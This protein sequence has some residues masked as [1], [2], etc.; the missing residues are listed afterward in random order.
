MQNIMSTKLF[1]LLSTASEATNIELQTAYGCF[2]EHMRNVSQFE[3]DPSET[4]RTLS[5]T[6]VELAFL[7]SLYR[8]LF[9][10]LPSLH[11]TRPNS[12]SSPIRMACASTAWVKSPC[13]SSCP[14]SF[15]TRRGSP[16]H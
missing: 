14:G 12:V 7:Q 13:R 1:D 6:R 15:L 5:V 8:R 11:P 4:F 2:T 10:D 9:N 3:N 16:P